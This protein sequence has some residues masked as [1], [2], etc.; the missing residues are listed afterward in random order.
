MNLQSAALIIVDVQNDFCTGGQLEVPSGEKVIPIVNRLSPIFPTV[1]A[2]QDW[3]PP[4]HLSFASQHPGIELGQVFDLNGLPQVA[5]PDHCVEHSHG[6]QFVKDLDQ[7][8]FTSVFKKGTQRD[9]DSYSGFFD[10]GGQ[11]ST[12]LAEFLTEQ[13]I[14]QIYL[15]GLATDYCVKFTALDAIK[16]GFET[17]L[18]QDGCRGVDLQPGDSERAIESMKSAGVQVLS[19]QEIYH[20]PSQ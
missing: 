17:C 4:N 13:K 3:H 20:D 18:I 11:H 16:C 8:H 9:V 2:T 14:R 1:V 5:W 10:N 19:S 6:A 7:S 15:L 12:G